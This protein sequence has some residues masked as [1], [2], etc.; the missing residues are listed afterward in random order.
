MSNRLEES[1]GIKGLLG[2]LVIL[3]IVLV[4]HSWANHVPAGKKK[5]EE[6][7]EEE[8]PDPPRNFTK[9]QLAEFDGKPDPNTD[10]PKKV[11]LSLNGTVFDVSDGRNFYGPGGPYEMFAGHECGIAL[12]KMS[13]DTQYLDDMDVSKLN[14]GEKFELENWIEKFTYYRNYPVMGKLVVT[15]PDAT[16][17]WSREQ[18]APYN[19]T[20]KDLPD[21]YATAP[22]YVG[23]GNKVFDVS[24]GGVTFYG[25]G[26]G[27]HRFAGKDASRAL[28]L[29]SFDEADILS[30]EVSDLPE[31]KKKVL[32]DWIK[33]FEE[34]KRYPIVGQLGKELADF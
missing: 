33:T 30:N 4:G 6:E 3:T 22:I 14:H 1:T 28:A 2:Y 18:L 23:A 12:A 27:Y 25:P 11:Y 8:E 15:L 19:G 17:V 26:C 16:K 32:K 34:R 21:G 13:F 7:E 24:F 5:L 9:G 29:M 20:Q 10:E 31:D